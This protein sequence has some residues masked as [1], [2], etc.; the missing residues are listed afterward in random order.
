MTWKGFNNCKNAIFTTKKMNPTEPHKH[1][2][3]LYV[4]YVRIFFFL[5]LKRLTLSHL[6]KVQY[7]KPELALHQEQ[8]YWKQKKLSNIMQK[9]GHFLSQMFV[10]F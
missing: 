7:F 8:R 3:E 9:R 4:S 2:V 6:E 1:L 5:P 10:F